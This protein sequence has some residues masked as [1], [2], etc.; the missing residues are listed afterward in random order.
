[1]VIPPAWTDVW[2]SASATGHL[3]STGRDTRGRKVYRYHLRYRASRESGKYARLAAVGLRMPRIRRRVTRDL[4]GSGL[5]RDKVLALVVRVLELTHMRV[6]NEQYA[7][8]NRSFGVTTLRRRHAQVSQG[9]VRFNFRGKSGKDHELRLHDRRLAALVRRCQEL[10]GQELFGYRDEAGVVQQV[11]SDDV[12][13]Y[14]R[15]ISGSDVTARDF[16]TWAGTVLA[17]RELRRQGD[18]GDAPTQRRQVAAAVDIVASQLG[19]T[20]TVARASYVHPAVIEAWRAGALP[21]PTRV[22]DP[23]LPPTPAEE[24]AVIQI[25]ERATSR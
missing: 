20:R 12:N 17:F 3:Q 2:I 25:L 24:R 21:R 15:R 9:E 8:A 11:R 4:R 22:P 7:A 13:D 16:R 6:G 19:N 5:P 14:L 23:E 10:P 1:L 18:P